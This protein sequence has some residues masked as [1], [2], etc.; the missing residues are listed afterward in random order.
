MV[1]LETEFT[2]ISETEQV[3]GAPACL[4]PGRFQPRV[5]V[6]PEGI[7]FSLVSEALQSAQAALLVGGTRSSVSRGRMTSVSVCVGRAGAR[8]PSLSPGRCC[9]RDQRLSGQ[10]GCRLAQQRGQGA[11]SAFPQEGCLS[12]PCL[13]AIGTNS[14]CSFQ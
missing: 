13:C 3:N 5:P 12:L 8:P 10:L 1:F 7:Q 2:M 6:S 11:R 9:R 4:P 14:A